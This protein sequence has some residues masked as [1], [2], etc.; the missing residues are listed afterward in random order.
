MNLVHYL[1]AEA[2][3]VQRK[4][5][6]AGDPMPHLVTD[7]TLLRIM[8]YMAQVL[9]AGFGGD[10]DRVPAL[11]DFAGFKTRSAP[12]TFEAWLEAFADLG[13][14]PPPPPESG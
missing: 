11:A 1:P 8:H 5:I 4:A 12:N 9:M 3:W 10:A 13:S 2:A 6:D 14:I 7:L